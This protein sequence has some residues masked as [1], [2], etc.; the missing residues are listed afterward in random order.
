MAIDV[1]SGKMTSE[2]DHEDTVYLSNFE[3][4][5]VVARQLRLRDLGGIVVVDFIDMEERRNQRAVEKALKDATKT[6]R[7]RIKISKILSSCLCIITRQRIR[8]GIKKS[9]QRRCPVC[10]GTGWSALA[11]IA[12]CPCSSASRPAWPKGRWSWSAC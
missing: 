6:D 1:N 7:A 5:Q 4:A 11:R 9:F 12:R 10:Q 2:R 3:A 8:P